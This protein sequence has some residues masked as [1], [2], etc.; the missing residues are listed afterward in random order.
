[1]GPEDLGEV[2][3]LLNQKPH[4]SQVLGYDTG[5]DASVNLLR[6]DL[7]LVQ[8]LDFFMPIVDDPFAFGQIAAA[9][10]LSDIYAMGA[11]PISALAILGFPKAKLPLSV[12]QQI[13]A[14]GADICQKAGV[15]IAGGHS[16]DDAEPKFGLSVS[17]LVHPDQIW[18]N[19]TAQEGDF[20]V[21]TKP[22]GVGAMGQGIKKGILPDFGYASFIR[23]TTTLNDRPMR[24]ARRIG[25]HAATDITGFGLLGH[26]LEMA[27]GAGL[28]AEIGFNTLP[29]L[30]SAIALLVEGI[31]PGAT[32]RNLAYVSQ[33]T[34]FDNELTDVAKWLM[35][36]PQTSGG[37]LFAVSPQNVA[38]LIDSLVEEEALCAAVIGRLVEGGGI[39]VHHDL[40][41][42]SR[43]F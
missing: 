14:G 42:Y 18:Q 37:L 32:A 1:M 25:V 41:V 21:L 2:L 9:N 4:A 24:A 16:I 10:S 35:T 3:S 26:V 36:D 33:H 8:S 22:L 12:A 17:G 13:M 27:E 6:P 20:L 28:R 34:D 11:E 40:D 39:R 30:A 31:K 15:S 38:D 19:S 23:N 7:A 43:R 5:D 29:V